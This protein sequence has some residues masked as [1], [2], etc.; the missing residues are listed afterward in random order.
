MKLIS[1]VDNGQAESSCNSSPSVNWE[2]ASSSCD[3]FIPLERNFTTPPQD[4]NMSHQIGLNV[5]DQC[6]QCYDAKSHVRQAHP[7]I[8]SENFAVT[9]QRT[10]RLPSQRSCSCTCSTCVDALL[11]SNSSSRGA[12]H[13]L[14]NKESHVQRSKRKR[15]GRHPILL[16]NADIHVDLHAEMNIEPQVTQAGDQRTYY[17][18]LTVDEGFEESMKTGIK[19]QYTDYKFTT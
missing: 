4:S 12:V 15:K 19:V 18:C 1:F 14:N 7:V 16:E 11:E 17:S 6:E 9:D 8:E 2:S 10:Q 3:L 5:I 13:I